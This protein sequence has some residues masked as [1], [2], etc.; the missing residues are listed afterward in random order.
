MK[1][2]SLFILVLFLASIAFAQEKEIVWDY[3]VKPG[4]KEW[5]N[6]KSTEEMYKAISISEDVLEKLDTETLVQVCLNYPALP[7]LLLFNSPQDGF[8]NLYQHFNGIRELFARKDA[9]KFLLKKY[10]ALS[11]ND[12]NSSWTL[13]KQGEFVHKYY[14]I[15]I[16]LAQSQIV[17]SLERNDKY[18]FL[19]EVIKKFEEKQARDDLFGSNALEVNAWILAGTLASENKLSS[20]FSDKTEIELSLKSGQLIDYDIFSIYEQAKLYIH[21]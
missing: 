6:F 21:E 4:S 19:K 17:E 2:T 5:L 20:R 7:T 13:E 1:K 10:T 16:I 12:F 11:F 9:G 14:Y 3:P 18:L 15:E 8:D